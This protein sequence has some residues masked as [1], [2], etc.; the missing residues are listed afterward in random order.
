VSLII[1]QDP[2]TISRGYLHISR[3]LAASQALIFSCPAGVKHVKGF[4]TVKAGLLQRISITRV[5]VCS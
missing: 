2:D 4:N 1:Y 5:F 3:A